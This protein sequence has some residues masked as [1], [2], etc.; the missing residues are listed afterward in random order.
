[1][2]QIVTLGI[3]GTSGLLMHNPAGS[4]AAPDAREPKRAGRQIPS[5]LVEAT[6]SLYCDT[7]DSRLH[8]EA[9]PLY[10]PG[11][12]VREACLTAAKSFRDTTRQGRATMQQRFAASVFLTR[13]RFLLSTE[14]GGDPITSAGEGEGLWSIH[15]KR[16]VVQGSGIMRSRAHIPTPW[17]FEGEFE[18]D[19]DTITPPEIAMIA[20]QAGK[21]PGIL[22]YRPGRTGPFGRF[23]LL[24]LDG[25]EVEE[26]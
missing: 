10:V 6:A 15:T 9:V 14:P 2:Y 16:A 19:T 24:T 1:M 4:M 21:F 8:D 13:E 17:F 5:P 7:P 23:L 3:A 25:E 22:D 26:Q 20:R 11:D 12:A 18:Y